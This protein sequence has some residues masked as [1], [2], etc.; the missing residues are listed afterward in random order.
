[1]ANHLKSTNKTEIV[2]QFYL[3]LNHN[4]IL[5]IENLLNPQIERD[6]EN[7]YLLCCKQLGFSEEEKKLIEHFSWK[8]KS[9]FAGYE[10]ACNCWIIIVCIMELINYQFDI[11]IAQ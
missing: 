6:A 9:T 5:T 7:F 10:N 4:E 2:N 8:W 11:S 3:A 1:M